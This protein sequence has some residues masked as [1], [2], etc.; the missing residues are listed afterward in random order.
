M[1]IS[2]L[3]VLHNIR[4]YCYDLKHQETILD[5]LSGLGFGLPKIMADEGD[6][7]GMDLNKL[8][9]DVANTEEL[10]RIPF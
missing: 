3:I 5:Y 1:F 7:I 6:R 4:K 10:D 2:L 8:V 9:F